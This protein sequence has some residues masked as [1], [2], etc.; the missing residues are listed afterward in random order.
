MTTTTERGVVLTIPGVCPSVNAL[1]AGR[2]RERIRA[3]NEWW[4]ATYFTWL[5][6]GR[7]KFLEPVTVEVRIYFPTRR[8]RDWPNF[9]AGGV[10]VIID[11]LVGIDCLEC[12][13]D[14]DALDMQ[15]PT[16]LYDRENPRVELTIREREDSQP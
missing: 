4:E 15:R 13:D 3:K 5:E 10:K 14:D 11:A 2:L 1:M 7:P 6:A 16:M 12:G 9:A 8:K